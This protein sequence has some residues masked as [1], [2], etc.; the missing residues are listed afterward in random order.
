MS[1]SILIVE[2]EPLVARDLEETLANLGY[3]VLD[4]VD[5][6]EDAIE[7]VHR[8]EPDLVLMDI[9]L[10]GELSGIDTAKKIRD[11]LRIPIIYL[12]AHQNDRI[13]NQAKKTGPFAY[14]KK[15]YNSEELRSTIEVALEKH[16]KVMSERKDLMRQI[17]RIKEEKEEE[18]ERL[19]F[20]DPLTDLPNRFLFQELLQDELKQRSDEGEGDGLGVLFLDLVGFQQIND[21]FGHSYGDRVLCILAEKL[22]EEL[23]DDVV[24]ARWSGDLFALL[25]TT[26][27]SREDI[28]ALI[29]DVFRLSAF[30][31]EVE[32]HQ[33]QIFY[34]IGAAMFPEHG[35]TPEE[36]I[37]R[38]DIALFE[39]KKKDSNSFKFYD[40]GGIEKIQERVKRT[41]QIRRSIDEEAFDVHYQPVVDPEE[42]QITRL[43][44][45]ARWQHPSGQLL[46]AGEFVPAAESSGL[47]VQLGELI[48]RQAIEHAAHWH[49]EHD[50][51]PV[52]AVNVST[53]QLLDQSFLDKMQDMLDEYDVSAHKIEIEVTETTLMQEVDQPVDILKKLKSLG[54]RVGVDDFGTGY[55]SLK[56]LVQLPVDTIK[57]DRYFTS[58]ITEEQKMLDLVKIIHDLACCFDLTAVIEG[59]ETQEEKD[60]VNPFCD[61]IQG[62]FYSEPTSRKRICEHLENS[63]WSSK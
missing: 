56:Y 24:A 6:G 61:E 44:A 46:N 42:D 10:N 58:R 45:L 9:E 47:I 25:T 29:Q 3:D 37:T 5:T 34:S 2:D 13:L 43:E 62:F 19:A 40:P 4:A 59:V 32:D 20:H 63:D 17:E 31:F 23:P 18:V 30:P 14:L 1:E 22:E 38:A 51:T 12:T 33:F 35:S 60:L 50:W 21:A 48:L 41:S 57:I 55:S 27:G 7:S 52:V 49:R 36:L 39:S 26:R 11:T 54:V 28:R 53:K 15:P 16:R 8:N